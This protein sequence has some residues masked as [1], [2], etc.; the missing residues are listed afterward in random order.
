MTQCR[1]AH[2]G[3]LNSYDRY[4]SPGNDGGDRRDSGAA[5]GV[6]MGLMGEVSDESDSEDDDY[7][8]PVAA[9]GKNSVLYK[10]AVKSQPSPLV[11]TPSTGA[12]PAVPPKSPS[13]EKSSSIQKPP[14]E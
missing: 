8:K 3:S 4:L 7:K 13:P 1:F 10:A 6:G 5:F 12:R 14:P 9:N 11:R 2:T